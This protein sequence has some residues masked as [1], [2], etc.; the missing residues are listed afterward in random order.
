MKKILHFI[1]CALF[2]ASVLP[3]LGKEKKQTPGQMEIDVKS[4]YLFIPLS[5]DSKYRKISLSDPSTGKI[6]A[7][8]DALLAFGP[9][10]SAWDA[11][12]NV[13]QYKGKKLLFKFDPE[14]DYTPNI[15]QGDFPH[16]RDYSRDQGRP[17]FHYTAPNGWLNDPNGLVYFKGKWHLF[18]QFNPFS[19][20]WKHG[21]HWAH[22]SSRDL[23]RW[24]YLP[25]VLYPKFSPNGGADEAFSGSAY[26]DKE[27]KSGL[28]KSKDGGVIF[29]YTSTARG[30]CLMVSED[31]VNF[32]ELK[33]N[34]II[35]ARGRDPRIF[36]N[37]DSGLWTI[38]RYEESGS[39]E[40]LKK[41]FA[42]YVSKDLEKWEK[43]DEFA[44]GFYECPEFVKMPVSG[45]NEYKWVAMDAAGN[46]IVGD[47]DGRKFTQTSRKPLRVFYGANYA[48]QFWNNAPGNRV[49]ATSWIRQPAELLR[50]V[51]QN[52]SQGMS[53]PWELRL[54]RL[55]DGQY[56][57]RASI[58]EEIASRIEPSGRDAVGLNEM[59]FGDNIFELPD[60][61]GNCYV[62]QGS[63]DVS[64]CETFRL[65][66]GTSVFTIKPHSR[67]Y[68]L[69]RLGGDADTYDAQYLDNSDTIFLT[70]FV[71]KY[72]VEVLVNSGEAVLFAGDS[73]I[74][75]EQ[76]I[77]VGCKGSIVINDF[78]RY[79]LYKDSVSERRQRNEKIMEKLIEKEEPKP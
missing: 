17:M 6:I 42:I 39:G 27:N 67:Q 19:M 45:R 40:N 43:T 75:P 70:I 51:G 25:T 41:F 8:Y 38:V 32:R 14:G 72:S 65:E 64:M 63:F 46:Y 71:D 10:N 26:Y 52:F 54:V 23:M 48:T 28:F 68:I 74:N 56:Q 33:Q 44:E 9:S 11:E 76:R 66:V 22:A 73:F 13:S 34:P 55:R 16:R 36:F 59:S 4:D 62:L 21:M 50:A 79:R 47:F 60:A 77:K 18:H 78:Y 30:E 31:M 37:N 24:D 58:P 61:Y 2:C 15:R 53:L 5:S 35:T 57:L 1:L 7:S 49:I 29:A 12:I 69:G 3:A 20:N